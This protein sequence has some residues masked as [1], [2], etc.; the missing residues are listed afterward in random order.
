MFKLFKEAFKTANDCIILAIPLVLFMWILSFYFG[1]S[2]TVVNSPAEFILAFITVLFMTGAFL[3]GWFYMVKNAIGISHK[4]FVM[5]ADRAKAT[6]NLFK[7]IPYGIG[8]YFLSFVL[9]SLTFLL[10]VVITAMLVYLIGDM[11][12]GNVFTPEQLSAALSSTQDMKIFLDSLDND[13]LIKL[14]LWNLLI[15]GTTTILSFIF[16]LWIPEIIYKTVNPL[17]ALFR[18]IKKVFVRFKTS[19]VVF[20]YISV[21][22]LIMSFIGT[23]TLVHP[24]LYILIMVLYFYFIIYVVILLFLYY[25]SEFCG[26][27]DGEDKKA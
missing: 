1:F 25:E 17:L 22:N 10:I 27:E 16:M 6:M 4:V 18:A 24:L 15:M 13:Q 2:N 21:L 7:D 8:Q 9:M 26:A 5:D 12:I 19:L 14:N 3:S 20:I 11:Y 23:F